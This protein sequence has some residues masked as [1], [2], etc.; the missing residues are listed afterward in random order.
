MVVFDAFSQRVTAHVPLADDNVLVTAGAEA[1]FLIYPGLR[2]IH[3]WNLQRLALDRTAALPIRGEVK[4]VAIGA[5]SAGPMLVRWVERQS[6]GRINRMDFSFLDLES[7]KVLVCSSF[8]EA[9]EMPRRD[10][11]GEM[12]ERGVLRLARYISSGEEGATFTTIG[13]QVSQ[14]RRLATSGGDRLN[15]RA[16]PRGDVF[17][18]W[19]SDV[20]PAGFTTLALH[21][22]MAQSFQQHEDFG[23]L[24]PGQ[25][26]RTV[27]T[28]DGKRHD[29][30]GRP[31]PGS[32]IPA[33][34][35]APAPAP[36][37]RPPAPPRLVPSAEP[38]YYLAIEGL[39]SQPGPGGAKS[40][41]VVAFRA[42]GST[43]RWRLSKSPGNLPTT[44]W[45]PQ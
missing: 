14:S 3:R 4:A 32:A 44:P 34:R 26:G 9:S 15:L 29:L 40:Q 6:G 42:S 19:Q 31:L 13:H 18:L 7:L 39:E 27:F 21:G 25:D 24:I 17:G 43:G 41:A 35:P 16:S 5:D 37:Q 1:F 8:R 22:R 30:V 2:I 11:P 10:G 45:V 28:G 20:S 23:H 36:N 12:P 38:A 33:T